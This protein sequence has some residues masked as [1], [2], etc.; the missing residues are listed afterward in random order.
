VLHCPFQVLKAEPSNQEALLAR[1]AAYLHLAD[2]DMAKRHVGEALKHDPDNAAAMAQFRKL[3]KLAKL[4][5]QVWWQRVTTA[6][7]LCR[8]A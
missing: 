7:Y 5:A 1:A 8:H 6:G 4:Q 3:K 2:L